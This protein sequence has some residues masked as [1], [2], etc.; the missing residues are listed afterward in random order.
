MLNVPTA[1]FIISKMASLIAYVISITF[2]GFFTA[3]VALKLGDD[4]PEQ[5]GFLTL[6]PL[7]HVD[8]LGTLFLML[9][10]FGW[11]RF[12]PI[13]P[14]NMHG[15]L[16]IVKILLAYL[17]ETFWFLI[18]GILSLLA[19]IALFGAGIFT[20]DSILTS[21][22]ESSSYTLAIAFIIIAMVHVNIMLAVVS[23]LVNMCGLG[24]MYLAEKNP[25][26]LHYANII[27]VLVPLLLYFIFRKV[28][29]NF[30]F[31]G[32]HY[33]GYLLATLLHLL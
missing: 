14:L 24:V 29:L 1:E 3:W 23:F 28:L 8:P 20:S 33:G 19:L 9:Y 5:E 6:N 31:D 21:F 26:Y 16:R 4:T 15:R 25:T 18:L 22:P 30:V 2:A 17:T 32:I 13:N 11:S 7:A 10:R 12:V 27:M